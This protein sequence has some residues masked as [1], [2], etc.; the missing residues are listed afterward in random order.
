MRRLATLALLSLLVAGV[1]ADGVAGARPLLAAHRGGA[2]LWPENSLLAFRN[3]LALGADYLETDVHL[4]AD[5]E[6]PAPASTDLTMRIRQELVDIQFGR[7]EDGFGW[8]HRV[9]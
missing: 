8:M 7:A 5:G 2:K 4:T 9:C 3:A 1:A 6:V